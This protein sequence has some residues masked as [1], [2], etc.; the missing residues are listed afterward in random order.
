MKLAPHVVLQTMKDMGVSHPFWRDAKALPGIYALI[1]QAVLFDFGDVHPAQEHEDFALDLYGRGLFTLPFPVTAFGFSGVPNPNPAFGTSK[2]AVAGG[3]IVVSQDKDSSLSAIM[4]TEQRNRD[5]KAMGGIPF[6][7]M[8]RAKFSN[9]T[10]GSVD[11][12]NEETHPVVS[13][14]V[15]QLMY[16]GNAQIVHYTMVNRIALNLVAAMGMTVMLMSKG[17]STEHTP[18]PDKLN[19][20]RKIRGKVP[21][22]ETYS[23]RLGIGDKY[24][25][26]TGAGDE[27]IAGHERGSPRMHWRRGHFRTL[28]RGTD[29][30]RV[31]PVAPALIG[32]NEQAEPIR[33]A[34]AV[35]S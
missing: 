21:I 35:H 12:I 29:A 27:N 34:Y 10:S 24:S 26:S 32:A 11:V 25:I 15:L 8:L 19:K 14:R 5:G 16:E 18:A 4:C 6:A 28:F 31:V 9:P 30:E 2:Q 23:V 20:A 22:G 3:M 1:K 13:Q 33:K 17:V 7:I